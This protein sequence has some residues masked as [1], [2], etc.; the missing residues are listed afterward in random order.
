MISLVL[1]FDD[2]V[3]T[4]MEWIDGAGTLMNKKEREIY[5]CQE[6]GRHSGSLTGQTEQRSLFTLFPASGHVVIGW[7]QIWVI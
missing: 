7:K 1:L 6:S 3:E 5:C 4:G 2:E